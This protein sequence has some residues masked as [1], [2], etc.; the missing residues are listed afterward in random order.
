MA[1]HFYRFLL[2]VVF[3]IVAPISEAREANARSETEFNPFPS[4]NVSSKKNNG[5]K[6]GEILEIINVVIILIVF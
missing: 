4:L 5:S 6:F 1:Q 3:L 2:F